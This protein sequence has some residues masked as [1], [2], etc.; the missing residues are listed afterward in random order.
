M[1]RLLNHILSPEV[2]AERERAAKEYEEKRLATIAQDKLDAIA[3]NKRYAENT[4]KES[5]TNLRDE[6]WYDTKRPIHHGETYPASA[7]I[8][9]EH[10]VHD[11][12]LTYC[13][14]MREDDSDYP[15]DDAKVSWLKCNVVEETIYVTVWRGE[16]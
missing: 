2:V 3:F 8:I 13:F 15:D 16:K 6:G 1:G 5:L 9:L 12:V 7:E 14:A 4:V 11:Y 10:P